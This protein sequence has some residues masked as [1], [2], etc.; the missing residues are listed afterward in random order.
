MR[1]LFHIVGFTGLDEAP[2]SRYSEIGYL[3]YCTCVAN[4]YG[5][6]SRVPAVPG[7]LASPNLARVGDARL[8]TRVPVYTPDT[9]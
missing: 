4:S 2:F 5:T 3:H 7:S 9:A 6:R 1:L 8:G